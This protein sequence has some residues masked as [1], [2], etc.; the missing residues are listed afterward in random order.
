MFF[1]KSSE[2]GFDHFRRGETI[3]LPHSVLGFYLQTTYQRVRGKWPPK[4][5]LPSQEI[6]LPKFCYLFNSKI[7]RHA[8]QSNIEYEHNNEQHV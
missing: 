5:H 7:V 4:I 1:L 2:W 3:Q 6:H 8:E